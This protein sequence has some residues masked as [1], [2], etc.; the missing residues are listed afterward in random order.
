MDED[1]RIKRAR[2][3][4][5]A[6]LEGIDLAPEETQDD[7]AIRESSANSARDEQIARDVP[8]HHGS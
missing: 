6:E 4:L 1:E 8:P 5:R 7:K 3:R 2:Q